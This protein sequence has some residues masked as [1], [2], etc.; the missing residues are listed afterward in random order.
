MTSSKTAG[1]LHSA[2]NFRPLLPMFLIMGLST[3]RVLPVMVVSG[4]LLDPVEWICG[5]DFNRFTSKRH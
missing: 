5:P 2:Q 4:P 3:G 1:K